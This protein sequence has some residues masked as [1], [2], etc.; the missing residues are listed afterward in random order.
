MVRRRSTVRFRKGAPVQRL[1]SKDSNRLWGQKWGQQAR[2]LGSARSTEALHVAY[3][4]RERA[5]RDRYVRQAHERASVVVEQL[6]RR[7]SEPRQPVVDRLR[8]A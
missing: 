4:A 2:S 8:C 7:V 5:R 1:N 3:V 6:Q